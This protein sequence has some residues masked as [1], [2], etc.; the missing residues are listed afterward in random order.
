MRA[1]Q[2][3]KISIKGLGTNRLRSALT[4]LGVVIGVTA[5]VSL[6]SIGRGSQ[7]AITSSIESMGTNLLF[8]R[9]G[10]TT[11][12]GVRQA[13]GTASTLTLEDAEVI[14]EQITTVAA[15]A[16]Q[17]SAM[18]QV[19]AGRQ[20]VRT[21]VIGV[22]PEYEVVRNFPVSYGDFISQANVQTRAMVVVLGSDVAATLFPDSD[23]VGQ[24][25]KINS[26]QYKVI[27]VLVSKGSTVGGSQDDQI[28]APITTVQVRLA[29]Q[30]TSSGDHVV[31]TINVQVKSSKETDAAI[32]A[33]TDL[34][35]ERHRITGDT[36][37]F[38]IS[39]QQDTIETLQQ[40]TQVWVIFLGAI[41]GIS[42]LVGGI[43]IMNIML[44][45]VTERTREIGIR[46]AV[47]AKKIDILLQF[48]TE[49]AILSFLGGG[50]GV[51][52][53]LGVSH[54]ISGINL[55]GQAIETVMSVDIP[56]LAVSVSA[57]IG[58]VFGLYPA[59]RAAN[60]NP[61]D[62]LRYE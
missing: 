40:T 28:L 35:R 9:P 45:S 37:D 62:A 26:Y 43:G 25:V 39:S 16:P 2:V 4:M 8:I 5:V 12:D 20:N 32:Q 6:L 42:L 33:I 7:A 38:S 21:Q 59:F 19:V 11:E 14:A 60:L 30:T 18:V 57:A 36:N 10:A 17:T 52:A 56:I 48:L 50:L 34:L 27:G 13:S 51:L 22:T 23:P 47:G 58:I 53:G 24:T 3:F 46:K 55:N 31:Q 15:V 41:A 1:G 44:V 61:I 49:A 54:L 29:T